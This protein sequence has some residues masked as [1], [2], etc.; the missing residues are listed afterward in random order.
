MGWGACGWRGPGCG[1]PQAWGGQATP[2][3]SLLLGISLPLES[4]AHRLPQIVS[5]PL[6]SLRDRERLLSGK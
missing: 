3:W 4:N 6:W 1:Q 5:R 2:L